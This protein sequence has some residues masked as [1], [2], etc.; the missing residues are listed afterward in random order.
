LSAAELGRIERPTPDRF[1]GKRK[2]YLVPL[3]LSGKDAPPEIA[4]KLKLYWEQADEQVRNLEWRIGIVR[5]VFHEFVGVEGAAGLDGL[6]SV[7]PSS[8]ALAKKRC[9][10]GA[11]FEALEDEALLAELMDWERCLLVGLISEKVARIVSQAL[12]QAT[13]QRRQ[14]ITRKVNETLQ[15]GEACLLFAGEAHGIQFAQDIEVFY[16]TPP[17]LDELA[18]LA[19]QMVEEAARSQTTPPAQPSEPEPDEKRL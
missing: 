11:R 17:A 3:V 5:R 10:R 6:S 13:Q 19:K 4:D 14:H 2:V 9:E 8:H 12:T 18:R 15:P 16:V 7:N 1:F